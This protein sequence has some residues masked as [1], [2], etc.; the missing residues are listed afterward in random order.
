MATVE[1]IEQQIQTLRNQQTNMANEAETQ[2]LRRERQEAQK[3]GKAISELVRKHN[4]LARMLFAV[5]VQLAPLCFASGTTIPG[6]FNEGS[7]PL[8]EP[9]ADA[10]Q[11]VKD[12]Y[13]HYLRDYTMKLHARLSRE[14]TEVRPGPG[15]EIEV[16]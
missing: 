3:R 7:F 4:R 2:R 14:I 16:E 1:E 9:P 8:A 15:L 6:L 5:D 10:T 12:R 11:H 13:A